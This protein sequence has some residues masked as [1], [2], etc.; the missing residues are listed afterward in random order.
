MAIIYRRMLT[1]RPETNNADKGVAL[2][3]NEV[4]RI[5]VVFAWFV[6]FVPCLVQVAIALWI[7]GLQ[8]GAVCIAPVIMA[9]RWFT[10]SVVLFPELT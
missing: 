1:V 3:S 2:M 9:L 8:L 4:D 10:P 6:S 7:L 5:T